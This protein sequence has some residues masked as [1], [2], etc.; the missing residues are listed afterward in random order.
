MLRRIIQTWEC[1][2]YPWEIVTIHDMQ[3]TIRHKTSSHLY[4]ACLSFVVKVTIKNT[5]S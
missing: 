4:I 1:A 3:I 5:G 2:N